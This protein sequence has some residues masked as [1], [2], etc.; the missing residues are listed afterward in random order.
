MIT[1]TLETNKLDNF[2]CSPANISQ[3]HQNPDI[4]K[5][6]IEQIECGCQNAMRILY[7]KYYM[8][9]TSLIN[10]CLTHNQDKAKVLHNSFLDIWSGQKVWDRRQSVKIFILSIIKKKINALSKAFKRPLSLNGDMKSSS[11]EYAPT[12]KE[13]VLTHQLAYLSPAHRGLLFL[14]H[15]ENLSYE[16]I[17]AIENSS[18]DSIKKQF[19]DL[20]RCLK[21]QV[22]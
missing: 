7:H 6:L 11:D 8:P 20:L 16:Q 3:G 14:L 4:D 12:F 18:V 15:K 17:A 5:Y 13:S 10:S 21:R 1:N 2:L 9:L 22:N 19:L